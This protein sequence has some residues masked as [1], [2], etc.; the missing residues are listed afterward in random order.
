ME[1]KEVGWLYKTVLIG[2]HLILTNLDKESTS[3]LVNKLSCWVPEEQSGLIKRWQSKIISQNLTKHATLI[4][5]LIFHD[6]QII[7]SA[8]LN[9]SRILNKYE[10]SYQ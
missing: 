9:K 1:N 6:F 10:N 8:E 5:V 7:N 2:R 3:G 4:N